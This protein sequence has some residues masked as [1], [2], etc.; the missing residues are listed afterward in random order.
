MFLWG[1][2]FIILR[3]GKYEEQRCTSDWRF[4]SKGIEYADVNRSIVWPTMEHGR[5]VV[6]DGLGHFI[7]PLLR[8]FVQARHQCI[9]IYSILENLQNNFLVDTSLKWQVIM[10][11][12]LR[13]EA[14]KNISECC[15]SAR[16]RHLPNQ[17]MNLISTEWLS[18]LMLI[19]GTPRLVAGARD[20]RDFSTRTFSRNA[21]FHRAHP[22]FLPGS[23]KKN[24]SW[25]RLAVT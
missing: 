16:T 18:L 8:A 13:I 1:V 2:S 23:R 19:V 3:R 15:A 14:T 24:R 21:S 25:T 4:V 17:V 11:V 6:W 10:N 9:H 22:S 20:L 5:K 7:F 12:E